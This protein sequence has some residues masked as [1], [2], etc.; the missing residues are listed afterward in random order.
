MGVSKKTEHFLRWQHYLRWLVYNR[1]AIV[2]W[3]NTDD[4][5]GD[6]MTKVLPATTFMKHRKVFYNKT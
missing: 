4:E 5:T 3:V 1:Y 2:I 6:V